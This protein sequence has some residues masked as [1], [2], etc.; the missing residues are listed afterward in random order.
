M[1]EEPAPSR[2]AEPRARA[3]VLVLCTGNAARSVMAGALL[4]ARAAPVEVVTAGTHVIEN[5]PMSIR[6]RHAL[7]GIG[8]DVPVH[9][10]RQL[11]DEHV[12]RADLIIAMAAEHVRYVR[13]R[14]DAGAQRTATLP[15]LALN[16]PTGLEPLAERVAALDLAALDPDAQG[17]IADPAGGDEEDYASCARELSELVSALAA[18]LA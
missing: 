12:R 6:T 1:D 8:V 4:E 14:H 3:C 9:R 18:R 2:D 10:S 16:L 17:E 7:R 15:W 11:T 13:R 5:Q